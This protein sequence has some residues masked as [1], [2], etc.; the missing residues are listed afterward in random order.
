[1]VEDINWTTFVVESASSTDWTTVLVAFAT[2]LTAITGPL[3]LHFLQ[4]RQGR[5]TTRAALLAEVAALAA[6]IRSR[7]YCEHLEESI[8]HI[9]AGGTFDTFRVAIPADY[10]LIYRK[11][12]GKLGC[13]SP[14]EAARIVRFYQEIMEVICDMSPGGGL[15]EGRPELY[16][17][18]DNL[19]LIKSALAIAD[20]FA[21]RG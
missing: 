13:L 1:M 21:T 19:A 14:D 7:K 9:S 11:N 15:Y 6:L 8:E 3:L 18:E 12:A 4:Q 10:N 16:F 5:E 20:D 2:G 17:Y